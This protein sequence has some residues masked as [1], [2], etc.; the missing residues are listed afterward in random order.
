MQAPTS[1]QATGYVTELGNGLCGYCQYANGDE[2]AASF[3]VYYKVSLRPPI[4]QLI[5]RKVANIIPSICGD[6]TASFGRFVRS[7]LQSSS[8]ALGS[9]CKAVAPSSGKPVRWRGESKS[10]DVSKRRLRQGTRHRFSTVCRIDLFL[11]SIMYSEDYIS[12]SRFPPLRVVG[13]VSACP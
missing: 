13:K 8:F 4:S 12:I 2:F 1:Q 6:R 3:N 10:I 7:T 5:V 11:I 9:S